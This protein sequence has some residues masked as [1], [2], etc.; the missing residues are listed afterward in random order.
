MSA[1]FE[2]PTVEDVPRIL[3]DTR[4][5]QY[6]LMRHYSNLPRGRSVLKVAGHYVL[7]DTPSTDQLVA[8]GREGYEWFLGGHIYVI[9]DAVGTALEA[10]G[11]TVIHPG[12]WGAYSSTPWGEL[13][14]DFW[15]AP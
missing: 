15:A 11:Y 4:G 14:S 8:A 7:V 12:T 10:D 6:L 1:V 9:D 5:P 3:P 13:G 2:P